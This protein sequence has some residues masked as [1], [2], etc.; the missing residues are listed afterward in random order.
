MCA[1]FMCTFVDVDIGV[2]VYDLFSLPAAG[3]AR[4]SGTQFGIG[5]AK[6]NNSNHRNI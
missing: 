4:G 3:L 1:A 5:I 6:G 2:G